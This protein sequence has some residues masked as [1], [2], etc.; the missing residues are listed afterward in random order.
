LR[1]VFGDP[2]GAIQFYDEALTRTAQSDFD[3][4]AWL[5]TQKARVQLASGNSKAASDSLAEAFRLFP[6]SQLA[7]SVQAD[8]KR[9][10]SN[11]GEA[12]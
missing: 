5:L 1:E 7:A 9:T 4:R 8:L 11:R 10:A 12:K 6:D 3:Q 2:D